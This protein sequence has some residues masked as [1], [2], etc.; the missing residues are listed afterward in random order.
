M[1]FLRG[2]SHFVSHLSALL[3]VFS[4]PISICFPWN[5]YRSSAFPELVH[6][7]AIKCQPQ[8][9][10]MQPETKKINPLLC[11]SLPC[12]PPG[13]SFI[14]FLMFDSA[15]DIPVFSSENSSWVL[16]CDGAITEWEEKIS[17]SISHKSQGMT[18]YSKSSA[19]VTG[20]FWLM[21]W[22]PEG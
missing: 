11:F 10:L 1:L 19:K 15:W 3:G 6:G 16:C 20:F 7:A 14:S 9:H 2:F 17:V 4:Q 12:L 5:W 18:S 21:L 13:G 8:P 22:F